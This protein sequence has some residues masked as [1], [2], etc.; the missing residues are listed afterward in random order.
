VARRAPA[1]CSCRR[2]TRA[3]AFAAAKERFLREAAVLARF[4]HPSVVRI[5]EV[6][7]EAG[8]AYLVMEFAR[9]PHVASAPGRARRATARVAGARHRG[10]LRRG[11]ST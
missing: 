10:A 9:R 8:T 5:Y 4:N 7:E 11:R 1:V 2:P 6:F 3:E